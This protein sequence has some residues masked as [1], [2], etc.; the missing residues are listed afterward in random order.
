MRLKSAKRSSL[1]QFIYKGAGEVYTD[2]GAEYVMTEEDAEQFID[3][4]EN[5]SPLSVMLHSNVVYN[6]IQEEAGAYFAGD[7][8][9]EKVMENIQRRVQLYLSENY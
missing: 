2:D 6:I 9:V 3:M 4:L 1:E 7:Q 5:A 8:P